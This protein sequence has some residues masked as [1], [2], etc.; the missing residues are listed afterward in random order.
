MMVDA[1]GSELGSALIGTSSLTTGQTITCWVLGALTL[2]VNAILKFLPMNFFAW[3]YFKV[4]MEEDDNCFNNAFESKVGVMQEY[5][6]RLST[7]IDATS[8]S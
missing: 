4:N 7:V 2:G 5:Q 1:G 3:V 6:R 8:Y